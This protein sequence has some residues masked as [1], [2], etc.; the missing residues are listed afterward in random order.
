MAFNLIMSSANVVSG[1][2]NTRYSYTFLNNSL[3]ILDEAEIAISNF[4]IPYSWYNVTKAYDNMSFS[5]TFPTAASSGVTYNFSLAEGFYLVNDITAALQQFCILNGLYLINGSGLYVYYLTLIYNPTTYGVQ[6]ICSLVPTS[7]PVGW[8]APAGWVGFNATSYTPTLTI[9][10]NNFGKIIGF[11]A[12]TYPSA[13][14]ITNRSFLNTFV[15]L[16]SNVNSLVIRCSL[17]NNAIGMPSDVVDTIPITSTFGSN[18]N[19]M[20]SALKWVQLQAGTYQKLEISIVDQ[21]LNSMTILDSNVS[22]SILIKNKGKRSEAEAE[23]QTKEVTVPP[24]LEF[25]I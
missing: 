23:V 11:A 3:T 2:N 22:I 18:V 7:L 4:V 13:P 20:P 16:G 10:N 15:P 24:R 5:F 8:T 12:G 25:R 17:V 14:S 1:S 9:T 21:N 6:V 19:Y